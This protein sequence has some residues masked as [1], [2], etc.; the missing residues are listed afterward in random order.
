LIKSNTYLVVTPFFPSNKCHIG[1]YIFDQLNEIK[2]QSNFDIKLVKIVSLFSNEKDYYFKNFQVKIFKIID[3]PFFILPGFFNSINKSR[4]SYFLK[5]KNIENIKFS[6]SHVSYP[7]SYLVEDLECCKIIQHHGLDVLQLTN[8]RMEFFRYI[9]KGFLIRNTIKYLNNADINIGVSNL[10]LQQ[11]RNYKTYNPS[12]EFVLFN[13]VDRSK[14]FKKEIKN[15]DIFTI[16]CI[17]NFWKIKDHITLIKSIQSILE[18]GIKIKLRL[19][20]SGPTLKSCKKYV[21]ENNLSKYII[22]ENEIAHEKLND[23]YNS[24]DLFVLPSYFEAL[25][26]VYLESWATNTPFI[27]VE[28]QGISELIID[29]DRNKILAQVQSIESLK[30]KI[31]IAFNNRKSYP[32]NKKYDIKNTILNFLSLSIFNKYV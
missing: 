26:C 6:H 22:F 17:A 21:N 25:G 28:G 30:E 7:S 14:F 4:F 11:L 31:L 24:I 15:N 8:G 29:E 2:K 18:N 27:A 16:G 10:V 5:K 12:N 3:F 19:I 23:F 20:G 9:Q 13:G 32:F 1:S